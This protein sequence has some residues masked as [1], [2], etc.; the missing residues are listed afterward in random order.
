MSVTTR[1]D[2]E[3]RLGRALAPA[4]RGSIASLNDVPEALVEEARRLGS[5]ALAH[6]LI[7]HFIDPGS[8][9]FL[10]GFIFDVVERGQEARNWRRGGMLVP[11]PTLAEMLTTPRD[12][13]LA[14]IAG[15][16]GKRIV[17]D[18]ESWRTGSPSVG[19]PAWQWPDADYRS[20]TPPGAARLSTGPLEQAGDEVVTVRRWT[21]GRLWW[22]LDDAPPTSL[23]IFFDATSLPPASSWTADGRAA[24]ALLVDEFRRF[25]PPGPAIPGFRATDEE[26][27]AATA[28][29]RERQ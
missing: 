20:L 1:E 29:W 8:S 28:S 25:G 5:P 12:I 3:R 6:A 26:V 4:D 23:D 19:S 11:D 16:S 10:K 21:A 18:L 9:R 24:A 27:R 22:A 13:L 14:P 7:A 15:F 17:P 2:L